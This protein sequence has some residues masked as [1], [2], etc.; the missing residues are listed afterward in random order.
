MINFS[1]ADSQKD[2]DKN[3]NS[4]SKNEELRLNEESRQTE[5]IWKKFLELLSDNLKAG[6]I[7]TW[8]SVIIPKSYKDNVLTISVPSEDYYSLIES[9]YNKII[10]SITETLLG[11]EGRLNYEISQYGLFG[12]NESENIAKKNQNLEKKKPSFGEINIFDSG[13][14]SKDNSD[15]HKDFSSNLNKKHIFE[16]FIK[17]DSNELAVAAAYAISNNP[18]KTYNPFFVYGGV[19]LGKTHL[20]QAIGNEILK[21]NPESLLYN[22]AGFYN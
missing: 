11:N 15:S 7:N 5:L 18:G 19:G 13:Y 4:N 22:C 8:F 1:T 3:K 20:I 17:G 16:N 9:R 12:D 14:I 2:I 10:S 6:E 21:K